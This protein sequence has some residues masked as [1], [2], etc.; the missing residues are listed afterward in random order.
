MTDLPPAYA[1]LLARHA[2]LGA[3]E[4]CGAIL[5]WD[6]SVTMPKGSAEARGEQFAALHAITHR[7]ATDPL[8]A[9]LLDRA[10][11]EQALLAPGDAANLMLM[12]RGYVRRTALPESLVTAFARATTA[13]EMAW[14]DARA[15]SDFSA[16]A[17]LLAEIVRL[18]QDSAA[19]LSDATGLAPYDALMDGFQRGMTTA[20]VT[21]L[22]DELEKFLPPLIEARLAAQAREPAPVVPQGPFPVELQKQLARRMAQAAGLDFNVARLDESA[23]PFSGGT[24]DDI[25]ITTRYRPEEFAQS[26]LAV[27]HECGHALYQMNLPKEFR[28][29]PAGDAAGMAAHES[30]SLIIEMQASRSDAFLSWLAPRLAEAFGPHAGFEA[31]NLARLWRRVDRGFIRVE[32]DELSYPL[33][34]I[35][36]FRLEQA[37][38]GG[39]L[40]VADLPAAWNEGFRNLFGTAP[41][42]D[43]RGCLQDIHW[44]S[45]GFGYFPAYTLGAMSAA[46]LFQAAVAAEPKIPAALGRGDFSPLVGWCRTNVHE[47]GA[48]LDLDG[49]LSAATGRPLDRGSFQKHLLGRYGRNN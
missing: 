33:H 23:H 42:D 47:H 32:A 44:Y 48:M 26:V 19:R 14:R 6:Q 40:S 11:A 9:R 28:R 22:F 1:D 25:R 49:L 13:C 5:S 18:T 21:P 30:Q 39:E 8:L 29:Q 24:P 34:I 38:V 12:R 2:E 15:A 45:G 46:Q 36:R 37:L 20:Q 10:E 31:E 3:L 17:P 41:P 35:L 27:L 7:A 43:A 4:E 16:V